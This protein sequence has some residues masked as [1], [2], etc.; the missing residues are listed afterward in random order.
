MGSGRSGAAWAPSLPPVTWRL[1]LALV[2]VPAILVASDLAAT[3]SAL[4]FLL[5]P[6]FG[7]LAYL[8]FI[9]PEGAALSFRHIVL[10]MCLTA[11]W[12]WLIASAFGYHALTV[13]VAA[14][15]TIVIMWVSGA[16]RVVPPMA[17]CLLTLLL[18]SEI[19]WQVDYLLSVLVFTLLL[20]LFS[21]LWVMLP[22]D[23]VAFGAE[24]SPADRD[25]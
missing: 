20:W 24:V 14:T 4:Q 6:P 11:L 16:R 22:L 10:A 12:S 9:H 19:R 13:G 2:L 1:L 17:L 5:L 18:H 23:R 25:G 21:L 15:G 3:R 8:V 7:A